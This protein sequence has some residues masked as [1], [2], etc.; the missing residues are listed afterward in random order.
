MDRPGFVL[1]FLYRHNDATPALTLIV[2]AG[3]AALV[4]FQLVAQRPAAPF[5]GPGTRAMAARL[6]ALAD[7]FEKTTVAESA[8]M[9]F[10]TN[11]PWLIPVLRRM[12]GQ[13]RD[14]MD[15]YGLRMRLAAQLLQSGASKEA[16]DELD[17]LQTAIVEMPPSLASPQQKAEEAARLHGAIGL[18]ALRLGEQ[19]NCL[20]NHG[21]TSCLFP[22]ERSGVH[23]LQTGA[24]RAIEA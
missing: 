1:R 22:I 23:T 7:G 18:A 9:V 14:P 16:L 12:I 4:P 15:R 10:G 19:E 20:L 3:L 24:R 8:N 17:S 2:C 5:V 6:T 21:A 13:A 11:Q